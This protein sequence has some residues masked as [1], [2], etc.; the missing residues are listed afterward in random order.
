[1]ILITVVDLIAFEY[2]N[3]LKAVLDSHAPIL[4]KTVV[5]RPNKALVVPEYYN[6]KA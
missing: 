5:Q 6:L 4:T 2:S 1:M 3:E